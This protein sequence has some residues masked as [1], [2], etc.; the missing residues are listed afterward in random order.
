MNRRH[1]HDLAM[2]KPDLPEPWATKILEI[3]RNHPDSSG[4]LN[5]YYPLRAELD[6]RLASAQEKVAKTLA[7]ATWAL[8]LATVGLIAATITLGLAGNGG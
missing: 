5:R 1:C 3:A 4:G 2:S 6:V 8:V 7:W